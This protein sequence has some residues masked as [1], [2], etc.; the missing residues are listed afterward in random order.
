M[1]FPQALAIGP[2]GSV[3]VADQGSHVVQVFGPD[4]VFRRE[5]GIAGTKPGQ[6]SGVG[7][8]AVAGDGSVLVADGANRIDRFDANGQ[9]MNSWGGTGSDVGKFRFGGGRAATRAAAGGGLAVSGDVVYVAD[10][11]NDRIQRFTL[12]GGHGAEIVPP[13]QLAN[14]RGIAVRGTRLFVADDQHHRLVVFDTGGHLLRAVGQN[15][16]GPGQLN[17]PYGVATDAAGARVRRRRPQPPRRALQQRAGV[18]LQGALGLL[19]DGPGPARLPARHR[20]RPRPATSTWPTP[21]TTASTSSTRAARCCARSAPRAARAGQFDAPVGVAADAGGIRA[22][23][24]SVNG[25][26]AAAQP[27]RLAGVVLGLAGAGA[28]DPPRPRGRRLRR[29]RQRL[30]PRSPALADRRLR[31]RDG[32]AGAHDRLARQRP[33]PAAATP[34]R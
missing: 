12:D 33:G 4:G 14:P 19:R 7:A 15:G 20:G 8:I 21:A 29:R 6:L 27:R 16:S 1:R 26:V 30:R 23:T 34:R 24:D 3:Y 31:P 18:P 17:F 11:G 5:F 28:D 9:L 25:R 22:V 32:A 10:T 13:G 2:D